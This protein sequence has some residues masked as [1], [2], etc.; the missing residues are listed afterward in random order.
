MRAGRCFARA[1]ARARVGGSRTRVRGDRIAARRA[2][3]RARGGAV[4]EPPVA[5]GRVA[6]RPTRGDAGRGRRRGRGRVRGRG[7]ARARRQRAF[8]RGAPRGDARVVVLVLVVL[9]LVVRRCG[10]GR[11]RDRGRRPRLSH[12]RPRRGGAALHPPRFLPR[13]QP[14]PP[15]GAPR[16]RRRP[17]PRRPRRASRGSRTN[18]PASSSTYAWRRGVL[19]GTERSD[20]LDVIAR[21]RERMEAN[22]ANA[23]VSNDFERP[24]ERFASN[25]AEGSEPRTRRRIPPPAA[26]R[27]RGRRERDVGRGFA[28]AP[29]AHALLLR[30]VVSVDHVARVFRRH[31]SRADAGRGGATSLASAARVHRRDARG[32][33]VDGRHRNV[34]TTVLSVRTKGEEVAT[35]ASVGSSRAGYE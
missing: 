18:R 12:H 16:V 30:R 15:R 33:R 26:P 11:R 20:P 29:R 22:L 13:L 5:L 8:P 25:D 28:R 17:R 10:P 2:R 6:R 3:R 7:R 31:G 21:E 27:R 24:L 34:W 9:V 32:G 4:V 1:R 35:G 23:D 14:D 19:A